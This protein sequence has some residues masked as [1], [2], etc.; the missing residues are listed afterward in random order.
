MKYAWL[1]VSTLLAA[2][3]ATPRDSEAPPSPRAS[4]IEASASK[5]MGSPS[6]KSSP[7]TGP[8]AGDPS[9]PL[10]G[11]YMVQKVNDPSMLAAYKQGEKLLQAKYPAA[12]LRLTALR[13]I[14]TQVV[15]GVN[16]RM[17]ALYA[18]KRGFGTVVLVMYMNIK[19]QY[20]LTQDS[21]KP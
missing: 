2:C 17:E 7:R 11:G 18:D 14:A 4:V 8:F 13:K 16:Y 19:G 15:A 6:T 1:L 20:E 21:Y 10:P 3:P 9:P 5:P 12:G